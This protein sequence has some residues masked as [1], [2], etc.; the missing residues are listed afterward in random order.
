MHYPKIKHPEWLKFCAI[1]RTY[2]LYREGNLP[3]SIEGFMLVTPLKH[4]LRCIY[5]S[6]LRAALALLR[7]ALWG[8]AKRPYAY[9][10]WLL[11]R[12]QWENEELAEEMKEIE[13]EIKAEGRD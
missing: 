12:K 6:D 7:Q 13:D 8:H 3:A 4:A 10:N 1:E 2:K 9:A 5:G 11:H